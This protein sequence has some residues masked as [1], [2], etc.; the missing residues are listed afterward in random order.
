[1]VPHSNQNTTS[2]NVSV[3]PSGSGG[4]GGVS[5]GKNS[6]N[7]STGTSGYYSNIEPTPKWEP[8]FAWYPV[9]AG[10]KY[11]WLTTVYR[12][13]IKESEVVQK[14]LNST[15]VRTKQNYIYG[16]VFDKLKE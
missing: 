3:I 7:I 5:Y 10:E 9:K 15:I 4:S 11:K 14:T 13:A 2:I 6:M 1:M 12:K 8:W 16:T